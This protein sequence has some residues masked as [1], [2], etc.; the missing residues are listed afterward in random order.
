LKISPTLAS[1]TVYALI[2]VIIELQKSAVNEAAQDALDMQ[3][4]T[5]EEFPSMKRNY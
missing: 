2:E 4:I 1:Q 5:V 3:H